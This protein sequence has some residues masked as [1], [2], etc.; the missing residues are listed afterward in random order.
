MNAP[1]MSFERDEKPAWWRRKLLD[2]LLAQLRQ[3]I[4][5][6]KIAL[7]IALGAMLGIFPVLGTTTILCFAVG[8]LLR[9]NQPILQL[10]NYLVYPLHLG[11]ILVFIRLGERMYGAPRIPF[12]LPQ[13]L[14]KFHQ[15][16]MEFFRRFAMTFVHCV[17]AWLLV[18]P[19]GM[20]VIYFA[21]RPLLRVVAA[22]LRKEKS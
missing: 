21:T 3:G 13:L 8:A 16:P 1:A 10:V 6:E 22:R 14:A 19:F 4:T 7:T 18:A 17:S 9:L 5:P 11:L 20:A 2:P 12:S 15:A